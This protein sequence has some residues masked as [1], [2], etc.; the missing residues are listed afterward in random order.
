MSSDAR[1]HLRLVD[2]P[3]DD[4]GDEPGGDDA[5]RSGVR[6][7]IDL[8]SAFRLHGGYVLRVGMRI[9]GRSPEL[10]D[11]VQDV[12]L[13]AVRGIDRLRD[14]DS[15][16]AWLATLTVRKA[17]LVLRK[18]YALTIFG[19]NEELDQAALADERA[20]PEQRTRIADL[21]RV[22]GSLPT[23]ERLAWT[24]RYLEG[25]PLER[26]ALAC[27]CS[28]ATVKRRIAAAHAVLEAEL[29]DE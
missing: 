19:L 15:A 6:A 16:R 24:L 27:E 13:D 17:R 28:L 1:A 23:E 18:R 12:F 20:S 14:P 8:D 25:E 3:P 2:S 21:Y 5:E 7:P 29:A 10:D 22:L 11:L 4:E 26:V 9:L